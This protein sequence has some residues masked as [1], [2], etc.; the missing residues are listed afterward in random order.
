MRLEC[1]YSP[2][3]AATDGAVILTLSDNN[4]H[5]LVISHIFAREK[6]AKNECV[7]KSNIMVVDRL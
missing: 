7:D 1:N 3:F 4:L 5:R 6:T 2:V